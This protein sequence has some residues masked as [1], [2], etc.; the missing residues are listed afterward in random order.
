MGKE[1]IKAKSAVSAARHFM[2]MSQNLSEECQGPSEDLIAE[3]ETALED[4]DNTRAAG[5]GERTQQ[6]T[7]A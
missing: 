7:R 1:G 6:T 3:I 4:N 5:R 2:S